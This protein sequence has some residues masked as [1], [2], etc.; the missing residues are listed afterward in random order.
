MAKSGSP[1]KKAHIIPKKKSGKLAQVMNIPPQK[2]RRK[3]ISSSIFRE[4]LRMSEEEFGLPSDGPITLAC[5]LE[6]MGYVASLMQ[7]KAARD[8]EKDV[9]HHHLTTS[10]NKKQAAYRYVGAEIYVTNFV[11]D[12]MAAPRTKD[13]EILNQI[14]V[15]Y[16]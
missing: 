9:H 11:N 5:D 1:Q 6:F 16:I 15:G 3:A 13:A 10:I 8:V 4:L 12:G 7:K 2:C 14:R